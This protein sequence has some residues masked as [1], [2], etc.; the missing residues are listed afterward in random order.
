M[1]PDARDSTRK[2]TLFCPHCGHES[3]A[4][5]DWIVREADGRTVY[6]CPDCGASV[7]KR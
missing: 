2:T 7:T 4:D 6:D 1:V 3:D 5:G